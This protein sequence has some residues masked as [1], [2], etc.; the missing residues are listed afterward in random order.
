MDLI[1]GS[2]LEKPELGAVF[3]PTLTCIFA[4][5]FEKLRNSDKF[6]FEN[7]IPPS[8]FDLEILK[9]IQH[10]SL[11]GLLCSSGL[12][13]E[14]QP[15]SF[16]KQDMYLN[17]P[18]RCENIA[19]LSLK[20]KNDD[21]KQQSLKIDIQSTEDG[22]DPIFNEKTLKVVLNSAKEKLIERR[23]KEYELWLLSKFL[24]F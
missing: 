16:F 17:A 6:W 12:V 23:K 3:G 10:V 2:L 21:L 24:L 5:Q 7:N 13:K 18:V 20:E 14:I 4:Q 22:S 19:H 11:S 8:S 9:A 1:I 15:R